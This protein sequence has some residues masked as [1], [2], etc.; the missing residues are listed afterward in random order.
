VEAF[1]RS[2]Q[3]VIPAAAKRRAGTHREAVAVERW[4]PDSAARFRDD[5]LWGCK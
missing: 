2:P 4:V 1:E 5:K 3:L